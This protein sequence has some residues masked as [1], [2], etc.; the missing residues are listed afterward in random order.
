MVFSFHVFF[1][2]FFTNFKNNKQEMILQNKFSIIIHPIFPPFGFTHKNTFIEIIIF[3][4]HVSSQME[5]K[6]TR[7]VERLFW[8]T[9]SSH[10]LSGQHR[11]ETLEIRSR[12]LD[13]QSPLVPQGFRRN[14]KPVQL[15]R[16][17]AG[18]L[19]TLNPL[20]WRCNVFH[21]DF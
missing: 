2:S 9:F 6:H 19:T 7:I 15:K 3:F 4:F 21:G 11:R 16:Q 10:Q 13:H 8:K 12:K 17:T 5:D 1:F 20:T 14:D 18:P